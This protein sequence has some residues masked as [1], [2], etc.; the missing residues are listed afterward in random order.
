[1]IAAVVILAALSACLSVALVVMARRGRPAGGRGRDARRFDTRYPQV[2][3]SD[4][5]EKI[6]L[7]K[8][9]LETTLDAITDL[10]C[11]IDAGMHI[12]RVNKSYADHV[13]RSVRDLPGETC[14]KMFW[15][16]E[17]PCVDCPARQTIMTGEAA[18]KVGIF[19]RVGGEMRQ[20]EIG[21]YAV[22]DA[23]ERVVNV[24]EHIRDVTEERRMNEQLIRSEKLASIGIM[25][26]GIAHE[27]NNPLSGISGTAVNLLKT[28]EKYGLN[29][30]GLERVTMILE[31]AARA[32]MIM[33]DLL[34]FSQRQD[35][36]RIPTDLTALIPKA[37][38]SVRL[39]GSSRIQRTYDFPP[40]L[41][42]IRCDPTK[43]E[44]VIINIVTNAVQSILEKRRAAGGAAS[45][46]EWVHI[47]ARHKEGEV[48]IDVS[49]NGAGIEPGMESK[50][51]DPFFTTKAPGE[52]TGLGLSICHRII[53]EHQGRISA[54]SSGA[55]TTISIVLPV[56]V[57]PW[58][59][60]GMAAA[61][62]E[63]SGGDG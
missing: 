36:V 28:P 11:V 43:I 31:C 60:R 34:R 3:E 17:E 63:G 27:M 2:P 14:Y 18:K 5:D 23:R 50:I 44:Q 51:F 54:A 38:G 20:L 58:E 6:R 30:K 35:T 56:G 13:G 19:K 42:K 47:A 52:G 16:R 1:M 49:D 37:A 12:S 7:S 40:D 25:T 62:A 48:Y 57:D 46:G 53:E 29:E 39:P 41:P 4:V 9:Q 24:I 45:G 61:A 59:E 8:K 32:T 21:T 10:I 55:I 26:A 33:K 22:T 15:G